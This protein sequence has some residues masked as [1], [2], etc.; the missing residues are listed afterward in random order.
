MFTITWNL[1]VLLQED[2]VKE[3]TETAFFD[4]MRNI[5]YL[6]FV[7]LLKRHPPKTID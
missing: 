3:M 5:Q 7:Y 1:Q 6:E 2:D 4:I